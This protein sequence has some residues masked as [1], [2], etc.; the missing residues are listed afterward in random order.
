MEAWVGRQHVPYNLIAA[1]RLFAVFGR[2]YHVSVR[3]LALLLGAQALAVLLLPADVALPARNDSTPGSET[4][5]LPLLALNA[6]CFFTYNQMSFVVLSRVH[7][8]THAVANGFRRVVTIIA[9]VLY[10]GIAVRPVNAAG[11]ALV[12]S[13]A[14]L[15]VWCL[16]CRPD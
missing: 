12:R 8:I 5:L 9:A 3:G 10:F 6:L 2:R 1:H 11:M 13:P 7:V 16:W 14:V 15:R 4:S